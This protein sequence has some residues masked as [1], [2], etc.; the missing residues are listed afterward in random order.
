MT[1]LLNDEIF[2]TTT[3]TIIGIGG[4]VNEVV[5]EKIYKIKNRDKNKPL[6]IVVS[7][8]EQLSK[9]EDLKENDMY[10]INKYWPGNVTLIIN[11]KGYRMPKNEKLLE[12]I[13]KEGPFYLTSA[14]IS[15]QEV[16]KNIDEAKILFPNLK[17]FDFGKGTGIPSTIIDTKNGRK[18]R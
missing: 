1:K 7:S 9:M 15:N 13:K 2:I 6:V 10:Y 5:K 4:K 18:L 17:Y 16:V 3:D 14:N 11:G 8:I 12:F